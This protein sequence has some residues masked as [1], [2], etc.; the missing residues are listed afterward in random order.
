MSVRYRRSAPVAE[1]LARVNDVSCEGLAPLD[2]LHTGGLAASRILANLAKIAAGETVLDVGCGIGG[3]VRLLVS[4]FEARAGG[5]DL[6]PEYVEIARALSLKSGVSA[7]FKCANALALPF[8]ASSFDVVWT[9]HAATN[10]ADKTGLYGELRRV[11]RPGGRIA[12]HDLMAGPV[13][14]PLHL[15][16]PFAD[17]MA[18]CFLSEPGE[19]RALLQKLGFR[20]L[21]WRDRTAATIVFFK[22]LPATA[23]PAPN[24][25]GLHLLLGPEFA[26]MA[27]NIRQNLY[28]GRLGAAMGVYALSPESRA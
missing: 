16:L 2:Q 21:A 19:P 5:V 20:E 12:F 8:D 24:S 27:A 13:P 11:L 14:G 7:A 22:S 18:E 17:S 9:Q 1:I 6:S 23:D 10:I 15:P 28:E 25:L 4:E 26:R 3:S